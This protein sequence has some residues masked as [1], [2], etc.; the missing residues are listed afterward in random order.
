MA[1][2]GSAVY[3]TPH[4]TQKEVDVSKLPAPETPNRLRSRAHR[5]D[6]WAVKH[7]NL[8]RLAVLFALSAGAFMLFSLDCLRIVAGL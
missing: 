4:G 7:L 5:F 1:S 3:A 2:A 8:K 6:R